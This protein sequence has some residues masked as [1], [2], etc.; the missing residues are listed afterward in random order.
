MR[1]LV[2]D[3]AAAPVRVERRERWP[4][5][6][7]PHRGDVRG[8]RGRPALDHARVGQG[9]ERRH[10][11]DRDGQRARLL[12]AGGDHHEVAPAQASAREQL[13]HRRVA[14]LERDH[15][16]V[17][18]HLGRRQHHEVLGPALAERVDL[19]RRQPA[20]T[21]HRRDP[22]SVAGASSAQPAV[23]LER[24]AHARD[25]VARCDRDRRTVARHVH[26][27]GLERHVAQPQPPR[28][29]GVGPVAAPL[30]AG[31]GGGVGARIAGL[32]RG[33]PVIQ[34]LGDLLLVGR[35]GPLGRRAGRRGRPRRGVVT[36]AAPAD[37]RERDEGGCR[38]H[39]TS[40]GREAAAR[41]GRTR[42]GAAAALT[43]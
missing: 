43:A 29:A 18:R 21:A 31:R 7:E 8:P 42:A 15:Q 14:V 34:E 20:A 1:E 9:G 13:A 30:R 26:A 17:D 24:A 19:P 38:A 41:T 36:A 11:A 40:P 2:G 22:P 28:P 39:G 35:L 23:E 3:D 6:D 12:G 4:D 16:L 10:A 33:G 32:E 5:H 27:P 25:P 37:E